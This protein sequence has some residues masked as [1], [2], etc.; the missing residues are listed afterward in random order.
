MG[1][2]VKL[3]A[4]S[5]QSSGVSND[6]IYQKGLRLIVLVANLFSFTFSPIFLW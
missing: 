3:E 5:F 6:R 4:V 1:Y 2:S